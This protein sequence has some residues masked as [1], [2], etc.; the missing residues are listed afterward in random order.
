MNLGDRQK[1]YESAYDLRIIRNLPVIVRVDGKSFSRLTKKLERPYCPAM[2]GLMAATLKKT[3]IDMDGA[4]FGYQ[5][6]DEMTFVIRNDRS[7]N[8]DPWF[9][10]RVQKLASITASMVTYNFFQLYS[11]LEPKLDLIGNALFDSRAFAV[12]N[13]DECANNLV[14]RQADCCRNAVTAVCQYYFSSKFGRKKSESL[15]FKKST[16]DKISELKSQFDVDMDSF[17]KSFRNGVSCYKIPKIIDRDGEAIKRNV[18]KLDF[19][20][21]LFVDN[22]DWLMSILN[23]GHGVFES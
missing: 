1:S 9:A 3:I 17:P 12:P 4:I 2:L 13:I 6:S 22:R 18:W 11:E 8:T 7:V 21:E 10:N 16:S 14:F 20:T 15:L 23:N 5:Q 19:D